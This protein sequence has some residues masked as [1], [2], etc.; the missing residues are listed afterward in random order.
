MFAISFYESFV[1]Q[2]V[3]DIE[4]TI[5]AADFFKL[6]LKKILLYYIYL[7]NNP[8]YLWKGNVFIFAT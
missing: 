2:L 6:R 5:T 3:P 4:L 1:E 8:T 7:C